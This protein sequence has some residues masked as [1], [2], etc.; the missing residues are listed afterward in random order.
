M[1]IQLAIRDIVLID[2]LELGFREGL[3][4]LTGET[5]T[6]KSI[7]LDAFALALGGRGD[8]SLVRHGEPQGQVIAVFDCPL[9]HPARTIAEKADIDTD[10]DL[11]LRRVQLADGRTRAFVNDQPVSVQVLK[12]IGAALVE[13]HGQHDDRALMDPASHRAIL[14]AYGNLVLEAEAVSMASRRFREAREALL[15]QQQRM[16]K[17]RK[18]ADFLRF[19]VEELTTLA[20]AQGEEEALAESRHA[21]M[22]AE[23]VASDI[24]EALEVI[25]GQN[26]PTPQISVVMRRLE[27]RAD[28]APQLVGPSVKALD[29]ALVALDVAR[30]ALEDAMRQTEFDP[31]DLEKAEERLFSL[32]AAARKYDVQTE[33]LPAMRDR[34]AAELATLDAGE[35]QLSILEKAVTDAEKDYIAAAGILSAGRR[36]AADALNK[37]VQDELPPLK[38]ENARFITEITN[39]EASRDANGFDK[40][41]FW[42][43]TNPGTRPGPMMKVASGGELSRFM[44]ALKVVL[45]D[46]GSAPTLVFDEIDTGVGGA[47]ADAIGQRLGRLANRVQVIAVTH[48]PQVAARAASHFLI[49]KNF[50]SGSERVAT[51]VALL[52][53]EPRQEE[54]ARMLAGATITDEA[55]AAASRLLQGAGA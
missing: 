10:G 40:V 36:R 46:K 26:A 3:S 29:D 39:D 1:L 4:V 5:G 22:Q 50:V 44:L 31:R 32:R 14:D 23:K 24:A 41:E 25:A 9:D 54:I 15:S 13:I 7:L 27:R 33:E 6:G 42:T 16:D 35:E 30:E 34:F 20:A 11:I 53:T 43:Q 51:R 19:A 18:E 45:A 38:L 2:R 55:R 52:E 8:G 49:E 37:A 21:M 47:V 12:A 48:A 28:Q 17:A